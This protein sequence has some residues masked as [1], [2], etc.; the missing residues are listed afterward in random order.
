MDAREMS[1]PVGFPGEH[2]K[3]SLIDGSESIVFFTCKQLENYTQ[4]L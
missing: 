1:V 3:M 4:K 2:R